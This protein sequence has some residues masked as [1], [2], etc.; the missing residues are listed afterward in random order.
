MVHLHMRYQTTSKRV[1]LLKRAAKEYSWSTEVI[2]KSSNGVDIFVF[3]NKPNKS[4]DICAWSLM[5]G[6]EPTGFDALLYLMQSIT[7]QSWAIC[8]IIN[9]DGADLFQ[10]F[11]SNGVD[12][13]RDARELNTLEGLSL[14][15][16]VISEVPKLALN[17]HDQRTCFYPKTGH[18]PASFSLLAPKGSRQ[19]KTKSQ[20][21][22]MIYCSWMVDKLK[23]D[24][25]NS[26]A[27][28]DDSFYPSAFGEYFQESN[29]PTITLETGIS[30]DDWSRKRVHLSLGK[31]LSTLDSEFESSLSSLSFSS[32]ENL[33]ENANDAQDWICITL[34]GPVEIRLTE[35]VKDGQYS[36]YWRVVGPGDLNRKYWLISEANPGLLELVP[37]QIISNQLALAL[38][39]E[40]VSN[41]GLFDTR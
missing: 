9:P 13:N 18:T 38:G 3:R 35:T 2:G 11:N 41:L 24:Y 39:G 27:K 21:T 6:N 33:P 4:V 20:L 29:I 28:F 32:Y 10:R 1:Q 17:L 23:K 26:L 31:L 7:H 15:N 16:W 37:N 25:V 36:C 19:H 34:K 30:L 40:P 5:H 8:P 22:A 14:S 12:I